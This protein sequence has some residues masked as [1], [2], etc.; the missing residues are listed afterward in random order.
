M[1]V[2]YTGIARIFN[3]SIVESYLK[4]GHLDLVVDDKPS[5]WCTV[6]NINSSLAP[7]T[8]FRD[9]EPCTTASILRTG[10]QAKFSINPDLTRI[11]SS[12]DATQIAEALYS[13]MGLLLLSIETQLNAKQMPKE[14]YKIIS[15]ARKQDALFWATHYDSRDWAP[16]LPLPKINLP[17]VFQVRNSTCGEKLNGPT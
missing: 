5:E 8:L 6:N 13:S 10:D 3:A 16:I 17:K 14:L 9:S 11:V 15:E 4:K 12:A 7:N 1:T 2:H